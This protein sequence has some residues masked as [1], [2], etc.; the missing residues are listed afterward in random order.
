MW[1]STTTSDNTEDLSQYGPSWWTGCKTPTLNSRNIFENIFENI[2]QCH[3]N[4][5]TKGKRKRRMVTA[6]EEEDT[7]FDF[8]VTVEE[9]S[10]MWSFFLES[11]HQVL[12]QAKVVRKK[13]SLWGF[14]RWT[15]RGKANTGFN[16]AST[17]RKHWRARRRLWLSL[18]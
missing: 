8:G 12:V 6:A 18:A 4:S 2:T 3:P 7:G 1:V 5:A 11:P 9:G 14:S 16:T 10:Q 15:N 17:S 13:Y